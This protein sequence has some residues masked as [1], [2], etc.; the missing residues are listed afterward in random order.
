MVMAA[1]QLQI[2]DCFDFKNPDEWPRWRKR[3]DEFRIGSG[4][5]SQSDDRQINT[6][7]YCLGAEDI[8]TS[9]GI[10]DEDRKKYE[11]VLAKFDSFFQPRK[12]ISR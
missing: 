3:F 4:L 11:Q 10:S 2:P 7:L 5:S 1:I 9:T 6:L 12:K 8:L